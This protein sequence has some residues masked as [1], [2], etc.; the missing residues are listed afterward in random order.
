M[1]RVDTLKRLASP[2]QIAAVTLALLGL[3]YRATLYWT[4]PTGDEGA[5][6]LG[7]VVDFSLA[8]L[9]FLVCAGCATV[10]VG[11]ALWGEP[12]DKPV[13]YRAF[14]VG[15]LSFLGYDLLYPYVPR[16]V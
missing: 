13:A 7:P 11:I 6:G 5:P 9:L 14:F 8:M 12:R 16:L 15:V 4:L 10:G 3:G 2:L 1:T